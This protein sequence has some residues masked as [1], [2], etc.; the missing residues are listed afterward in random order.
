MKSASDGELAQF[1]GCDP[2]LSESALFLA[3]TQA[4]RAEATQNEAETNS[5]Q[6]L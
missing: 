4:T 3:I 2:R 1:I 6:E 5:T